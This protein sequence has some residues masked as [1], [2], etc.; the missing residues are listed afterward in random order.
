[1]SNTIDD[2]PAILREHD[3]GSITLWPRGP[4]AGP[5][6]SKVS[7]RIAKEFELITLRHFARPE[8]HFQD[9]KP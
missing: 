1:M 4:E 9:C 2:I 8:A 3:L 5:S 6:A 7:M